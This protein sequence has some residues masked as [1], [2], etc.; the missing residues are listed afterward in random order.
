LAGAAF[1][2]FFGYGVSLILFVL[3]LRHLGTARTGAY[4]TTA[5]FI[6]ALLAVVVLS[7]PVTMPLAAAAVLMAFGLWFHLTESHEH[8]HRHL[9]Q[10]HEH[11]HSHD[12]HHQHQ[13]APAD[14]IGEPHT[15]RHA[16]KPILHAHPHYP[17]LH[18]RHEH[19]YE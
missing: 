19:R 12:L 17:D 5:P 8:R 4:F 16:H 11:R 7:E 6:G 9:P 15:H 10:D 18:H 1:I 13:H 2:G 3:A 14:P